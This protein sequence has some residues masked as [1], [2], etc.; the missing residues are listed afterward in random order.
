MVRICIGEVATS[1]SHAFTL[2]CLPFFSLPGYLF[3][4]VAL[5]LA[6]LLLF[7]PS[8]G[9]H[10]AHGVYSLVV[11]VQ[12]VCLARQICCDVCVCL[13]VLWVCYT[14]V[15]CEH[16][17]HVHNAR[18][19]YMYIYIICAHMWWVFTCVLHAVH[20][21]HVI[22]VM[23]D[24]LNM[25]WVCSAM[26]LCVCTCVV[27]AYTHVAWVCAVWCML[28]VLFVWYVGNVYC[29]SVLCVFPVLDVL[30]LL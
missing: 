6:H 5:W 8:R 4:L 20:V 23:S 2:G 22:C 18:G 11:C 29:I 17:C 27:H 28:Y 19:V 3:D 16:T 13:G 12:L 25:F 10:G 24:V 9:N 7:P 15:M 30:H 26:C 21:V 14:Y 1:C